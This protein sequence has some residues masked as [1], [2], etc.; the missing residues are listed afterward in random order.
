[1][2]G[3]ALMTE[4]SPDVLKRLQ[5]TQIEI[6]EEIVRICDKYNL[7][8]F[9]NYGTLIGAIRHQGFIP[10]DDD[11]DI[12][13]IRDDYEKF[14]Q[15]AKHELREKFYLQTTESDP[16]YWQAFAKI[17][18]NGTLFEEPSVSS[19]SD[20]THKGI[21]V[22][23]FPLDYVKKNKGLFVHI[24]SILV[25]AIRETM[26]Y[27]SG[28]FLSKKKLRYKNLDVLFE[29]FS[30]RTLCR[31]Q[32][33]IECIQNQKKSRYL[34]DFNSIEHYLSA[35]YPINDFL[36]T[37]DWK[38]AGRI[39]KIPNNYDTYLRSIYGDYMKMPKEEERVNHRTLRIVFDTTKE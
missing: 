22:D 27:K 24:Q 8:Y 7:Q 10:W 38:F 21:F 34:A 18:K 14:L 5:E 13:M 3:N 30:M 26:Y 20:N 1:M 6:L 28:V 9:L 19:M 12:G 32:S 4:L 35:I 29:H 11:L 2:A 39:F 36:P 16:D 25:R 33:R 23:I 31:M 37:R 17:R 15:V